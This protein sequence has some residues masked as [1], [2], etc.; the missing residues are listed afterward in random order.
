MAIEITPAELRAYGLDITDETAELFIRDAVAMAVTIAPGLKT[1]DQD[2]QDA[3]AG[4]I[5]GAIVRWGESGSG[6][7]GRAH[8]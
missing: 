3:A 5:R 1:A 7:I 2:T 6:E 8:V 4:V